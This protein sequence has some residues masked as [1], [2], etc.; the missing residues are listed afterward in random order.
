MLIGSIFFTLHKN[1]I[2]ASLVLASER[3]SVSS[4][5]VTIFVSLEREDGIVNFNE[6]AAVAIVVV[7]VVVKS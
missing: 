3:S 1:Y 5:K 2:K 7:V 4:L 6:A